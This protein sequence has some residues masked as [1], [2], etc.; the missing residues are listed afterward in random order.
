MTFL[1]RVHITLVSGGYDLQG[2]G[3]HVRLATEKKKGKEPNMFFL[4]NEFSLEKMSSLSCG[5]VMK[6]GCQLCTGDPCNG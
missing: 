5:R 6:N 4:W 1:V 2:Q 3:M